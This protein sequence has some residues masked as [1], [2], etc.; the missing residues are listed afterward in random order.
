MPG[1]AASVSN[2]RIPQHLSLHA[3]GAAVK[4]AMHSATP[5]HKCTGHALVPWRYFA[6]YCIRLMIT[7]Q[8]HFY[9]RSSS[10]YTGIDHLIDFSAT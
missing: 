2:H 3:D 7:L 1:P 4:G 5:V 10:R 9:H 8:F 6:S